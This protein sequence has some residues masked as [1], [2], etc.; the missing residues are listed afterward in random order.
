MRAGRAGFA[1]I[2]LLACSTLSLPEPARAEGEPPI[3]RHRLSERVLVLTEDLMDNNIVVVSS[4]R[5]LIV[6]DTSGLPSTAERIRA[7]IAEEFGRDDVA[8]VVNTHYHWDH[9]FGNCA[10]PEARIIG[11]ERGPDEVHR[12]ADGLPGRIA[13]MR[14][15]VAESEAR[16]AQ[17]APDAAEA[18]ELRKRIARRRRM[19]ADF[20]GRLVLTP[21]AITFSDR[22]TLDLGDLTLALIYFGRAHSESDIFAYIPQ[23]GLLLTG[24][25]FLDRRWLPLFAGLDVLD[26]PRWIEVLDRFLAGEDSG[27]HP[28]RHIVPGHLDPWTPEKLRM[29]RDYIVALWEGL[30]GAAAAGLDLAA[31]EQRVPLEERYYYLRDLGHADAEIR[32]FHADNVRAFWRQIRERAAPEIERVLN[33]SGVDAAWARM[34]EMRADPRHSYYL[35]EGAI[36]A[37]GYRLMNA[38]RGTEAVEV[39]RMNVELSPEAWNAHDSLAEALMGAGQRDAA[40]THYRRSIELNPD[41]ENGKRMLARLEGQLQAR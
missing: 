3:G 7:A 8:F 37:L 18:T 28:I 34:R 2:V 15:D 27:E 4:A 11:H 24:D 5:G 38:D 20:E 39:F 19:L 31:A 21:P 30:G 10:F 41:N 17:L 25:V 14:A 40:I 13:R 12:D 36:D 16:L 9:S 29:W 35:D 33:E 23:E 26:V 1:L 22:M 6:F 32:R